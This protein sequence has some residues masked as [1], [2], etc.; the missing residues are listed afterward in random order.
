MTGAPFAPQSVSL[1]L[2]PHNELPAAEL[3]DELCRQARLGLDHGFDGI[4]LSEHHGGVG[5]YL[6]NP[7][8]MSGFVLADND[9]GWAAASPL[10]LPLRPTA[11]V[12]EE[13]AWLDARYPGRVGLGVAAGGRPVDFTIMDQPPDIAVPRYKQELPRIVAM[14]RGEELGDLAQDPALVACAQRPIPV[15]SAA[16]S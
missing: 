9:H 1:R 14:L 7:L 5:G 16:V 12:A 15:L 6:P 2:Y 10:L 4:M 8:Q 13:V 3:V 11:L